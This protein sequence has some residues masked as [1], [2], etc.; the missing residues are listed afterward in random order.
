MDFE[1]TEKQRSF[2][3]T[4]RSLAEKE[5][6]T[7]TQG[8]DRLEDHSEEI[9]RRLYEFKMMGIAVPEEYGGAGLDHVSDA[10]ALME[11]A[12]SC[13]PIG[14]MITAHSLYCSTVMSYGSHEQKMKYLQPCASGGEVG[15]YAL[16]EVSA[17]PDMTGLSTTAIKH[18][19]IWVING[20]EQF[21]TNGH[22]SSYCVTAAV[23]QN[24]EGKKGI[25]F[26]VLD[27]KSLN[28][29]R[30]GPANNQKDVSLFGASELVFEDVEVSEAALLSKKDEGFGRMLSSLD[31]A[32]V[33]IA[34]LAVGIGRAILE[35]SLT[36]AK[37]RQQFG[38]RIA[39]FQA[40]QWKLADM[41]TEL[42]A[43]ELM[44]LKA[45]W[46][47]DNRKPFQNEAAMAKMYASDVTMRAATEGAQILG[48]HGYGDKH[49]VDRF[50]REAKI[51]QIYAGTNEIMRLL[52][53]ENLVKGT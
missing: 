50:M 45:A 38:K 37:T 43:A 16:S 42:D 18:D 19:H 39:W 33:C 27:L 23:M 34:S 46:L 26:F 29:I 17:G 35:E 44:T 36:Y 48:G 4:M 51:C 5:F 10:L 13:G 2:R 40:V 52:V 49:A 22:V 1:L 53:A 21:V 3:N 7:Y 30:R 6:R 20:K 47:N 11:V 24:E 31:T 9:I 28:G 32:R 25:C 12:R 8:V 14:A 15:G 41:A